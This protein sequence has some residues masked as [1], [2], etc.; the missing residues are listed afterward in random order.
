MK[1]FLINIIPLFLG[2]VSTILSYYKY[3]NNGD[4]DFKGFPFPYVFGSWGMGMT[5]SFVWLYFVV[6]III[7]SI[8]WLLII[9]VFVWLRKKYIS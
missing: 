1:K 8:I 5:Y 3:V 9:K 6:D 4:F 2:I 7:W